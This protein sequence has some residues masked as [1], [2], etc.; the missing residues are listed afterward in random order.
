MYGAP[1][2]KT[3]SSTPFKPITPN[4]DTNPSLD[5]TSSRNDGCEKLMTKLDM[6]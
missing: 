5:S 2:P 6:L 1:I 4:L 3:P